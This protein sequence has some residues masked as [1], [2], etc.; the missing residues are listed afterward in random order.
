[1]EQPGES[2]PRIGPYEVEGE[3]ARGG[4]GVVF[5][6]RHPTLGRPVAIK[7]LSTPHPTAEQ[8]ERFEREARALARIRHPNVVAV[9]DAGQERGRPWLVMDLV[10][11]ETLEARLERDGPLAPRDAAR[12]A[13]RL[14]RALEA[15]H[16]GQVLH[17]DVKPENILLDQGGEP[18]LTDFG[19]AKDLQSTDALSR[20]GAMMGTPGYWPPEQ[21]RGDHRGVGPWSDVY[22]LGATLSAALTGQPPF[23]GDT[24]IDILQATLNQAAEPPSKRRPEGGPT[25]AAHLEARLDAIVLRCLAKEPGKRY[26]T[27]AALAADLEGWLAAADARADGGP[28]PDAASPARGAVLPTAA[29]VVVSAALL[30]AA[31]WQ[32][33]AAGVARVAA[34][35][36]E[37]EADQARA[38]VATTLAAVSAD[39]AKAEAART[40]AVAWLTS[41][42]DTLREAVALREE[43]LARS[44]TADAHAVV[45]RARLGGGDGGWAR[46]AARLAQARARVLD[47]PGA[48]WELDAALWDAT[49][50]APPP[51]MVLELADEPPRPDAPVPFA[52]SGP[53]LFAASPRALRVFDVGG[54]LVAEREDLAGATI[55][56]AADAGRRLLVVEADRSSVSV[57][58]VS[59]GKSDVRLV[60]QAAFMLN[61]PL[62]AAAFDAAGRIVLVGQQDGGLR[63]TVHEPSGRLVSHTG[64]P[65]GVSGTF[66]ALAAGGRRLAVL[67][68]GQV[69]VREV[70]DLSLVRP[71]RAAPPVAL[72]ADG[73][74]LFDG[75]RVER[76]AERSASQ[77]VNDAVDP[78]GGVI[79]SEGQWA[80]SIEGQR[81]VGV[82]N[83]SPDGPERLGELDAAVLGQPEPGAAQLAG[84]V[85]WGL[86]GPYAW[87]HGVGPRRGWR[88]A[89]WLVLPTGIDRWSRAGHEGPVRA[90]A[91]TPDGRLAASAGTD[92][93][94]RLWDT[95]RGTPLATLSEPG[96]RTGLLS[97]VFVRPDVVAFGDVQGWLHVVRFPTGGG[98]RAASPT[99]TTAPLRALA[100]SPDGARLASGH[101]DGTI[102]VWSC[103]DPS[104]VQALVHGRPGPSVQELA[105]R[106]STELV[107]V[108]AEGDVLRVDPSE[109]ARSALVL[110]RPGGAPRRPGGLAVAGDQA[111]LGDGHASGDGGVLAIELGG[112]GG[113]LDSGGALPALLPHLGP[114]CGVAAAPGGGLV[115]V[116]LDGWIR[117]WATRECVELLRT[118]LRAQALCV[119]ATQDGRQLAVGTDDGGVWFFDLSHAARGL[120][121]LGVTTDERTPA[122]RAR[123]AEWYAHRGVA[124]AAA[125]LWEE[126][127]EAGVEVPPLDLARA[128]WSS[129]DLGTARRELEAALRTGAAPRPYLDLLLGALE[130]DVQRARRR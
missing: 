18:R 55:V 99:R 41:A 4:M 10:E 106:G 80:L 66:C 43:L 44:S 47:A 112:A 121:L 113:R 118:H 48:L 6:A 3:L 21:A 73:E 56:V 98:I 2:R 92:G 17:R 90:V 125:L 20:S 39:R 27:A 91:V 35:R 72:S 68:E 64:S 104:S 12:L 32:A 45:A 103:A 117:L 52:A 86:D 29:L 36:A 60:P 105:W 34:D 71:S 38:E 16:L 82:L 74:L 46:T 77:V 107:A 51:L 23:Q 63:V 7:V 19:L 22:G 9:H 93:Q 70:S 120:G 8:R 61:G 130:R 127:R 40:D 123:A 65:E 95:I 11:G 57:F 5:R 81:L 128:A 115:S 88:A 25:L 28:R 58:E 26:V 111:F 87:C 89:L 110:G 54:R 1:M 37:A 94:L 124:F 108:T 84:G 31:G 15:A 75:V 114:V 97:V 119:A 109:P 49:L 96:S 42:R 69:E 13:A 62:L 14:A 126:A 53:L 59:R 100:L 102:V 129:G 83:L 116:G 78:R 101:A 24:L 85:T 79:A 67:R 33:R 50:R 122:A 30:G 76:L